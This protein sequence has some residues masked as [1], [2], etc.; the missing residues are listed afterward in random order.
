MQKELKSNFFS[1]KNSYQQL[2]NKKYKNPVIYS[3][4]CILL[5]IGC[6][7]IISSSYSATKV[8]SLKSSH[9][10]LK[11]I[12]F[13]LISFFLMNIFSNQA[14]NLKKLGFAIWVLSIIGLVLV[15]IMGTSIKGAARWISILGFSIQPSEFA[16]IGVALEGSKHIE[17][18]NWNAFFLTYIIPISLIVIQPDLGSTILLFGLGIGQIILK[19]FDVKIILASAFS[20]FFLIFLAY[21][22]FEHVQNRI[23]TFL[24][25]DAD[26]FGIGYQRNKSDMAI[27]SGKFIGKGFGKGTVK[28]YLPDAHTDYIF[29]VIVEEF[30]LIGGLFIIFLYIILGLKIYSLKSQTY[31]HSIVQYSFIILILAQAWLNIASALSL[32]PAKGLVLPLIS[33][34][35]SGLLVQGMNFGILMATSYENK[36]NY[37]KNHH[38]KE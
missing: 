13:A 24:K 36:L 7:M 17:N 8:Y 11:H 23:N 35:G 30:G 19:K 22:S 20:V 10:A 15:N 31:Y 12:I 4:A 27:K 21:F 33:Y 14:N 29:S 2:I 18:E 32:I 37:L 28:N 25:P 16:K 9:F 26:V 6:V 5:L 3:I 34:G 1:N 38:Y